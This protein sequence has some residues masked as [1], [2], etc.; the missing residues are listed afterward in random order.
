MTTSYGGG[1]VDG[2]RASTV[3]SYLIRDI[4]S[5]NTYTTADPIVAADGVT[6]DS[7][8]R[9]ES[10]TEF[11]TKFLKKIVTSRRDETIV[12]T[13]VWAS[14][15]GYASLAAA[16]LDF[17]WDFAPTPQA[18]GVN[19]S[20]EVSYTH[21]I[22]AASLSLD[23][24]I[25]SRASTYYLE[26]RRY[27]TEV[28]DAAD[29]EASTWR[30]SGST[31]GRAGREG[32]R[33]G[34]SRAAATIGSPAARARVRWRASPPTASAPT[35]P[36]RSRR[37]AWPARPLFPDRR[38]PC[39][40]LRPQGEFTLSPKRPSSSCSGPRATW[41][42]ASCIPPSTI[43]SG[44][45]CCPRGPASSASP[46]ARLGERGFAGLAREACEL[47]PASQPLDQAKHGPASRIASRTCAPPSTRTRPTARLARRLEA[48]RFRATRSLP[49]DGARGLSRPWRGASRRRGSA[50][51]GQ[52]AGR[53]ASA[54]RGGKALRHD[55]A[56]AA[57]AQ[58]G[59]CRTRFA[60]GRHLPH[61][62]LPRQGDGPEHPR[63]SAS[64][65]RI[66]EPLWNQQLR[67]PRRR[68]PWPRR[69]ASRPRGGYYEQRRRAARHASR[70]TCCSSSRSWRW[71]RRSTL[72]APT[73][74]AT[75][76][77]RCCEAIRAA[78]RRRASPR[79]R[80]AAQYAAGCDRRRA[81]G[82]LPATSQ[83]VAPD[84]TTETFAALRARG[85]QLALGRRAVL[86]ARRASAW[87]APRQRDRRS[88]SSAR[89]HRSSRADVRGDR[90][91]PNALVLR[92]QPEE[93]MWLRFNAKE[94]GAARVGPR[95]L[96]FSYRERNEAY[97]P[98]AYER[99]LADA[100]VRGLHP[101]HPGRQAEE[102]PAPGRRPRG[103]LG[104]RGAAPP[105]SGGL[106]G[107]ASPGGSRGR[108]GRGSDVTVR[109]FDS[110]AEWI[111]AAL[112]EFRAAVS[113]PSG[114]A[115]D[116]PL[117][118]GEPH[119][120]AGLSRHGRF[121]AAGRG[122][123][124]LA[125]RRAGRGRRGSRRN[126]S[127]VGR[128]FSGCAW[129]PL[130]ACAPGPRGPPGPRPLPTRRS[131]AAASSRSR[132]STCLPRPRG[133]RPYREPLPRLPLLDRDM[134]ISP[135]PP[136]APVRPMTA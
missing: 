81:G 46:G 7:L 33:R 35:S 126:G 111:A 107:A 12:G 9:V 91:A 2:V 43:S 29:H 65:T 88:A 86:P 101:L 64:P 85:R 115:R 97:L 122:G 84:S 13:S 39:R 51:R 16:P 60:R 32:H 128:A 98:E 75:R 127:M 68:S 114:S 112:D 133:G 129:D 48:P 100:L 25:E 94:P 132:P 99:L 50:R 8:H 93:G 21:E 42:G 71:S 57:R 44:R 6:V 109:R 76:R 26:G 118:R 95:E 134:G 24:L 28:G 121:P 73:P 124:P 27:Y 19:W 23:S 41:P 52:R 87:T 30:S 3:E 105:L 74:S 70:T 49:G 131:L 82:R 104:R 40:S 79:A 77:S 10:Y 120:G 83:R 108:P 17:D 117:P 110:E 89:P 119:A 14:G 72:R 116:R 1:W 18:S 5:D 63:T 59:S 66:F 36:S 123:R 58:L 78:T 69:S 22:P 125:R 11:K 62:P 136:E 31:R 54:P 34:S 106:A 56:S 20:S 92:I 15:A 103:G 55:L 96:R 113:G 90:C 47:F 4:D 102:A 130:P 38:R 135:R 61:R 37:A 67:R 53:A 80:C 45:A